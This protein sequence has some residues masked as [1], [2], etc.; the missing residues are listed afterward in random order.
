MMGLSGRQK[1]LI[2]EVARLKR[3]GKG[4]M[5]NTFSSFYPQLMVLVNN[6]ILKVHHFPRGGVRFTL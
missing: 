3:E 6:G 1:Y 2:R 4:F 5:T